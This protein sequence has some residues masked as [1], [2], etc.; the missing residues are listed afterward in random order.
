M[1]D[2]ENKKQLDESIQF[3]EGLVNAVVP[4]NLE[5]YSAIDVVKHYNVLRN[6]LAK[7]YVDVD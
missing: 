1:T 7:L 5:G 4:L 6:E 2:S 3:F